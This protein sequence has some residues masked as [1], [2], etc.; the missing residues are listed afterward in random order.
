ML[1]AMQM[2]VRPVSVS[3]QARALAAVTVAAES[4][5]AASYKALTEAGSE[6]RKLV[7]ANGQV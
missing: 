7:F 2:A 4:A 1:C 3:R 5:C 6:A